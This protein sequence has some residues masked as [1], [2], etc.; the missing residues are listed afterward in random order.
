MFKL[1]ENDLAG[2]SDAQLAALFNQASAHIAPRDPHRHAAQLLQAMIRV[3]KAR[4]I[5]MP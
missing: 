1:T 4:R 5:L 2:K 3:E